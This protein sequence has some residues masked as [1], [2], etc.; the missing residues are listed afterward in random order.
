[1]RR[2]GKLGGRARS[3]LAG[4]VVGMIGC[5]ELPVAAQADG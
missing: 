2:S 4:V 5:A 3:I 1:L